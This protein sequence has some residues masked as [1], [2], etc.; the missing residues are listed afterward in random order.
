MGAVR[1]W[2]D[3]Q[4]DHQ[5][6]FFI[7]DMHAL[8]VDW[9]PKVLRERTLRGAAQLLAAGVDPAKSAIFVQSHIHQH[10]E[11]SIHHAQIGIELHPGRDHAGID[12]Q[13]LAGLDDAGV[14]FGGGH[15]IMCSN[16]TSA[17]NGGAS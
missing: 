4:R 5:P 17:V 8:T 16:G 1:Q 2:V 12:G 14:G 3:L 15:A 10:S 7:A 6:F 13:G 9:D 11:L